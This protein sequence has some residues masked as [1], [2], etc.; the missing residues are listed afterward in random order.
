[1]PSPI[2]TS[3]VNEK[4]RPPLTTLAT[5]LILMTRDSRSP[6]SAVRRAWPWRVVV[7]RVCHQNSSPASRAAVGDRGDP[8]VVEEPTA[9]EHDLVDAGGLGPLGDS[10]PT[11]S[12]AVDVAAAPA[13]RRSASSVEAAASVRPASSSITCTDEVLVRTEDGEAGA[14]RGA[15]DV[16]AH[17]AVA[18]DARLARAWRCRLMT[19]LLPGLAGLAQ[20]LLARVADALALV[21]LGL[22]DARGC[23]RRPGRRLPCRCR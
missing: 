10:V 22:A 13:A 17:P 14:L 3:A 12:A 1:M 20:D 18:A 15:A 19:S 6:P 11:G 16:L 21:G 4:R 8:A 2:T 23:W 5:R 7:V 9:V